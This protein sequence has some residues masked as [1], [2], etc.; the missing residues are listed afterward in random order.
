MERLQYV[1][2]APLVGGAGPVPASGVWVVVSMHATEAVTAARARCLRPGDYDWS[3]AV[4]ADA[5]TV[6]D[7]ISKRP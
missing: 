7:A 3:R 5:S 1:V 2:L 6:H 4:A